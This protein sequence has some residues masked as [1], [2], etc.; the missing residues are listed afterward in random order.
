MA[1]QDLVE[2]YQG[3][4]EKFWPVVRECTGQEQTESEN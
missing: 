3:G 1:R 2:L 4:R